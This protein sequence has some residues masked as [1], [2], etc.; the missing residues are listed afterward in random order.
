MV[1]LNI[2]A[3]RTGAGAAS[4]CV[5]ML[6]GSDLWCMA[7]FQAGGKLG[8]EDQL[9][10]ACSTGRNTR[11]CALAHLMWLP[12]FV[13]SAQHHCHGS[14]SSYVANHPPTIRCNCLL[15]QVIY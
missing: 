4:R 1:T 12:A 15:R 5:E 11:L 2:R 7:G 13:Y 9:I 14:K 6:L 3:Q 8:C 10:G